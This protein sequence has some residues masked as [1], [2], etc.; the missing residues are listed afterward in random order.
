MTG[1]DRDRPEQDRLEEEEQ[2]AGPR[3]NA[4]ETTQQDA[5]LGGGTGG[6]DRDERVGTDDD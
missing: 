1:Q 2:E 5:G 3:R 6:A 4:D